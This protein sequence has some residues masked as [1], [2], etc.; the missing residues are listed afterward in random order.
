MR[1]RIGAR[2]EDPRRR[3]G[4]CRGERGELGAE[5]VVAP[6]PMGE[7]TGIASDLP[8]TKIGS[9]F[10]KEWSDLAAAR[11]RRTREK[12]MQSARTR[13]FRKSDE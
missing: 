1:R 10:V 2:T 3:W 7:K 12:E 11:V 13:S 8:F 4:E 9:S 5:E 6:T